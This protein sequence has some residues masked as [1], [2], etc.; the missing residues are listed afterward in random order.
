MRTLPKLTLR[1]GVILAVVLAG[2][3]GHWFLQITGSQVEDDAWQSLTMA[4]NLQRHHVVSLDREPPYRPSTYREPVPV[5]T[6]ALALGLAD[7]VFGKADPAEHF[8]GERARY[9]KYQNV[10]WLILL[11]TGVFLAAYW[12]TSSFALSLAGAVWATLPFSSGLSATTIDS[13]Y[14]ELPAAALLV[15]A[16]AWLVVGAQ[17]NR[18][19]Y[20]AA[21]GFCFGLLA[22][23]KAAVLYVFLGLVALLVVCYA[24]FGERSARAR[25]VRATV[26]MLLAFAVVVVPWM[27]RNFDQ[28][29]V[30]QISSRGGETLMS[31]AILN[32]MSWEEYR[33]TLYAWGRRPLRPLIGPMLGF[34]PSDLERGGRLPRLNDDI[35]TAGFH[36]DDVAAVLA[37]DPDAALSYYMRGRAEAA[38]VR[39][40]LE[41]AGHAHPE[42]GADTLLRERALQM[43]K[44]DMG[45]HL[46]MTMP[47]IWRGATVSFAFLALALG[48]SLL[49]RDYAISLFIVPALALLAFYAL[50]SNV[51]ITRYEL[52]A[53][54][55]A[56]VVAFG[57]L[58][59]M[60][61]GSA[62][63]RR[64]E[65]I[66]AGWRQSS[67]RLRWG[68]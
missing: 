27:V 8:S 49:R 42:A 44:Q 35:G 23:T 56:T 43:I 16:S 17:K 26:L 5:V 39:R 59:T 21:S 10:L 54:P 63:A 33:G 30:L 40:E 41:Q 36:G 37:G 29:G 48:Y 57:L 47:L 68:R 15:M 61:K 51:F 46:A 12:F 9:L 11:W 6:T 31:R 18:L 55:V 38:K 2:L 25:R 1:Q 3:C 66:R 22:L 58:H 53:L 20:F 52:P 28:L 14:T 50:L 24:V 13:L 4:L 45:R 19:W 34:S 67:T 65:A 62:A 32:R 64:I 60:W 7:A